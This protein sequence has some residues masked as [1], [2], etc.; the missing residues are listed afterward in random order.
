[1]MMSDLVIRPA[2]PEDVP[3]ILRFI[4]E[5]AEYERLSHEVAAT[6]D[7]LRDALFGEKPS[8]EAVIGWLGDAPVGF[9]LFFTTF[10]TFR[11]RPGLYLEDLYVS[12]EY[13][14]QGFGKLLLVNLAKIAEARGCGRF[15]WAALDWNEPA[16]NFYVQLGATPMDEWTTFRVAGDALTKLANLT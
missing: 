11:A 8:A 12:P 15:E 9:A 2:T 10:S 6:E 1:M 7:L 3:I 4:R 16:V 14:R 5:L 13:R